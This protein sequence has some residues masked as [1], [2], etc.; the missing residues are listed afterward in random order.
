MESPE[1][2]NRDM[3]SPAPGQELMAA[4]TG[5][6][7]PP[8]AEYWLALSRLPGV[9]RA[10]FLKLIQAYRS[11]KAAWERT[12]TEWR[13]A[14][15]S[16]RSIATRAFRSEALAWAKHQV[17]TLAKS[18]WSLVVF[19]DS[20]FPSSLTTLRYAPPFFFLRGRLPDAPAIAV[21]GARQAA[22]YGVRAA[23]MIVGDL[24]RAGV[25]IVSGFAR[26]IDTV[27]HSEALSV[28][29]IT[30]AVWGSGPDVVYP[31]ENKKLVE[32]IVERGAILTEFPFGVP[33]DRHNFP[34]RNR[35]IAGLAA[36]VLVVQARRQSG[37]LLTAQHALEQ[38]KDVYA[39][40]SEIGREQFGGTLELLKQGARI[41]TGADDILGTLGIASAPPLATSARDEPRPLPPLTD[42]E[43]RVYDGL[44]GSP[45]HIDRLAVS[46]RLSVGECARVL[47]T[48]ELKGLIKKSAGNLI[49]HAP[50]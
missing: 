47:T 15:V 37:A 23:Q 25:A 38:G 14:G 18:A 7:I 42:I 50:R 41:V 35:L 30:V 27:A 3:A 36:G 45:C 17:D 2:Q 24:A 29:G 22:E 44:G 9:G 5:D 19:G 48:L 16:R 40:P 43:R 4:G 26:G 20:R 13:E 32:P 6:R 46:L 11:P 31:P 28:G 1:H 12:D 33:P 39:I 8:D 10:T 49:S 21:V 34:V